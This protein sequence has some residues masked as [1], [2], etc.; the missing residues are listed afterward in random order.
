MSG[1]RNKRGADGR[2][3]LQHGPIELII[4]MF[5]DRDEVEQAQAQAVATFDGLL[6]GLVAELPVLRRPLGVAY[7]MLRGTIAQAMARAGSG[8]AAIFSSAPSSASATASFRRP[9]ND[10]SPPPCPAR[11]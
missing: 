3:Y 8:S 6:D 4:E 7:P 1:P 10:S 5:G 9:A 11:S 2:L